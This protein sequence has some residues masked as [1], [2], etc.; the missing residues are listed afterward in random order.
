M[1]THGVSVLLDLAL[2]HG[3]LLVRA[4][5]DLGIS[6]VLGAVVL[7]GWK[8]KKKKRG[9]RKKEEEEERV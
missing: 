8:K 6:V 2:D 9:K 7:Q 3:Q 1:Q 5:L 4:L